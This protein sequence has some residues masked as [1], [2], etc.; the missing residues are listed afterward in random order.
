MSPFRFK[1]QSVLDLRAEAEKARAV[2]L[3]AARKQ[4]EF[5]Q[6]A[7]DDLAALRDVG[8]E[9]LAGAHGAGGVVGHLQNLAYVVEQVDQKVTVADAD[10]ERANGEVVDSMHA[11]HQ[12][13][14]ERRLLDHLKGLRREKWRVERA[15]IEQ[16]TM[17]EVAL[18]RFGRT[19]V[20]NAGGE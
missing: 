14:R 16:Q 1:L 2:G 4:A 12:A 18:S 17:D 19:R 5:A 11:Y 3:A 10:C 8:R 20:A 9:R 13:F 7:R 6:Q 15:R